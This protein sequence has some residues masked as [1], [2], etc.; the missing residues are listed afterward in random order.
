MKRE[1]LEEK[2][3]TIP[4]F[5]EMEKYCGCVLIADCESYITKISTDGIFYAAPNFG[6]LLRKNANPMI[7]VLDEKFDVTDSFTDYYQV[8]LTNDK[9]VNQRFEQ[10][11]QRVKEVREQLNIEKARMD[12]K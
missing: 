7:L 10:L 5:I 11:V 12:F 2:F 1:E 3:K 6:I 4:T 9:E 8:P